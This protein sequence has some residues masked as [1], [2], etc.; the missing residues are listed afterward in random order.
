MPLKVTKV[1]CLSVPKLSSLS[2]GKFQLL[3]QRNSCL[4][5]YLF[6]IP[7]TD[8]S[9]SCSGRWAVTSEIEGSPKNI[10]LG[11]DKFRR[12]YMTCGHITIGWTTLQSQ[13]LYGHFHARWLGGGG[14]QLLCFKFWKATFHEFEFSR[15]KFVCIPIIQFN[16]QSET[17]MDISESPIHLWKLLLTIRIFCKL[18]T[19][20]RSEAIQHNA[21]LT[22]TWIRYLVMVVFKIIKF[23]FQLLYRSQKF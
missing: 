18:D 1:E 19:F 10:R 8:N 16:L 15:T 5:S 23:Q 22:L 3:Y 7:L 6:S 2:C 12:R 14:V 13:R 4:S 21:S 17:N 11:C 20:F 9:I